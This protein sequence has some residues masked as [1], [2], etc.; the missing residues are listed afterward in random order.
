MNKLNQILIGV[1]VIQIALAAFTLW[2]QSAAQETGGPLLP[3][4][5]AGDLVELIIQDG[6][7]NRL[8]LGQHDNEW[9][10]PEA[11]DFPVDGEKISPLLE[12]LKGI[13]T[14]RLVTQT[15]GSHKRLKVAGDDFNHLLEIELK[16]G[17]SHQL[18]LGSSAGAGATHVRFDGQPEVYLTD[19]L[20]SFDVNA[21]ASAWIDPLYYTVPQTATVALTLENGNGT[22]EFEKDGENWTM[23]GLSADETFNAGAFTGLLNQATSVRMTAPIGKEE[24]PAFGLDEPLATVTLKTQEGEET[25]TYTLR[26]GA[27]SDEDN[28]Y[29][30]SSSESPY[31]VRVA[32]FTGSSFVEKTRA[33]FLE[34]PP[35]G[36][37]ETEEV[38]PDPAE[39][40]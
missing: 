16:D 38:I 22:F 5:T 12:K 36:T 11:G 24:Q 30:V 35:A 21:Q 8:V 4:F 19:Q 23:K 13:Q 28:S 27:K 20:T 25:K 39:S 3:D 2:P 32:E 31:F 40:E 34:Q 15:E 14:N 1:L 29:I 37:S 33:D 17:N 7:E 9:V 6:D 10:L 26:V 18:Y